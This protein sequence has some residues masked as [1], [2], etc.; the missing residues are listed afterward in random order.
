MMSRESEEPTPDKFEAEEEPVSALDQDMEKALSEAKQKAEDYMDSWK[1]AQADFINFKRRTEQEKLEM[2]KYASTQ[3]ILSL[4]PILD[5]FERAFESITSRQAKSDWV[6]GFRL[7]ERK[8]QTTLE[9]QGLSPIKAMGEPFDP[10]LHEAMMHGKGEDGIVVQEM[11][12][13]YKVFDRVIRPSQ[14]V[15]GNGE[16]KGTEEDNKTENKT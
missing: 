16:K 5:D 13:G 12:K 9:T 2:G 6:E 11:R 3:L 10:N 8:L 4:L 1:R 14:V 15:V 7:I